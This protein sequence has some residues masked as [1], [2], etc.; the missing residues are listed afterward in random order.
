MTVRVFK[1]SILL[2][3]LYIIQFIIAPLLFPIYYP[4]SNEATWFL[5]IS[6]LVFIV[7]GMRVVSMNLLDWFIGDI[8]Y[9]C[10]VFIYSGHG[11]YLT[12]FNNDI[13]Y[14]GIVIIILF[15]IM[16]ILEL[17]FSLLFK[18]MGRHWGKEQSD[19]L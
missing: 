19:E 5:F 4:N 10:L 9:L 6:Y 14:R 7:I 11:A 8:L 15:I 3:I 16:F 2:S 18:Y 1:T 13:S 12:E 17:T